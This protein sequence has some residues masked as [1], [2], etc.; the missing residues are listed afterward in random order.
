MWNSWTPAPEIFLFSRN[1]KM[2]RRARR[3]QLPR[4]EDQPQTIQNIS[5]EQTNNLDSVRSRKLMM[6]EASSKL[7]ISEACIKIMI[8]CSAQQ[9]AHD[10]RGLQQSHDRLQRAA[11][12]S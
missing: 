4:P 10:E 8:D 9:Q 7:I 1:Q 11:A 3:S 12:S 2:R 5:N 6:S